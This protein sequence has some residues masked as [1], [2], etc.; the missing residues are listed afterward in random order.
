TPAKGIV[1]V[2]LK[3]DANHLEI[4]V[5]N[6]GP[7]IAENELESIFEPFKQGKNKIAG[8]TGLGLTY[9]R[10]LTSLLVGQISVESRSHSERQPLTVFKIRQ[11]KQM[12]DEMIEER[13]KDIK[14][15]TETQIMPTTKTIEP[16]STVIPTQ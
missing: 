2:R 13:T 5:L 10:Y 6:N 1:K 7:S 11:T 4:D 14:E 16:T 15:S 8:G 3:E 12:T 9:S